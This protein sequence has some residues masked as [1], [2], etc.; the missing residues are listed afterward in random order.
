MVPSTSLPILLL[1]TAAR[2]LVPPHQ[3][4][5]RS[6]RV[7]SKGRLYF[8]HRATGRRIMAPPNTPAFVAEV[9]CLDQEPAVARQR[10]SE[11]V[12]WPGTWGALVADYRASPDFTRL[13]DRTKAD[14]TKVLDY[15]AALDDMPLV[16]IT[17]AACLK[18][19]DRTFQQRKRR[20]ANYVVHMLSVVLGWASRAALSPRMRPPASRRSPHRA[21]RKSRTAPGLLGSARQFWRR[22]PVVCG[23]PSPSA[24]SPACAAAM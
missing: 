2:H 3:P 10:H 4:K 15:L 1:R 6:K 12:Y 5:N 24:C 7:R 21:M 16:Q 23:S 17:S 19:R 22:R 14:Y 20:F 9:Q 13:A 8:Y 11:P 18:I